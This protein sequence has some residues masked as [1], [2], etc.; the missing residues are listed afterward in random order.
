MRWVSVRT[1]GDRA[2]SKLRFTRKAEALTMIFPT[3]VWIIIPV[4]VYY[5]TMKRKLI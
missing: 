1:R 4:V 5:E 3:L 2:P